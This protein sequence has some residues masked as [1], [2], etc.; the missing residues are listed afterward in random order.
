MKIQ[1]RAARPDDLP[2]I[3]DIYNFYVLNSTC[4]YQETPATMEERQT[5]FKA[6]G[7]A[8]PVTVATDE[9]GIVIG[10]GALNPFHSRCAYRFTVENSVYVHKDFHRRGIGRALLQD[11]LARAETLG[12]HS[13]LAVI[14]ADQAPSVA[15]HAALGF[16]EVGRLRAVGYKFNQWLDVVYLQWIVP[17]RSAGRR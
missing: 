13:V 11:L 12:H 15:I 2:A 4:T 7:E 10:W 17:A 9:K 3:N 14:S 1:I 6:H 16:V 8:H 5:W